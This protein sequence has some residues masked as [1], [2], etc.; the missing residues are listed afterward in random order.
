MKKRLQLDSALIIQTIEKLENRVTDRFPDSGLGAVC[1][2][3]AEVAKRSKPNIEWISKPHFLIRITTYLIIVLGVGGLVY[4]LSFI[5][6][7]I[8]NTTLT[9]IVTITEAIFNDI[10]LLGAAM[11]F[12]ISLETRL[13]RRKAL[14]SLNELRV[15]AH[16]IDMHQLTKDPTMVHVGQSSTPNSPKRSLSKFELQRYLDYCTEATALIAKVSALYAQ[17]LPDDVVVNATNNIE[18]LC[19]GLSQKIWQKIVILNQ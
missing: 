19:T 11:Y 3:F 13:K 2:Q 7:N 12:L 16:V 4:S 8:G 5:E 14:K 10:L 18:A 15:I 17:S 6:F 9:N 1:R